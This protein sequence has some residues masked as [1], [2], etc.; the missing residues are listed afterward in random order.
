M[1]SHIV[2]YFHYANMF[3]SSVGLH[4]VFCNYTESRLSNSEHYNT[5]FTVKLFTKSM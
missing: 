2:V 3:I 1:H 4:L 5:I